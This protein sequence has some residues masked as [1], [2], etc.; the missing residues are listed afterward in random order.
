MHSID[1]HGAPDSCSYKHLA[2]CCFFVGGGGGGGGA[3]SHVVRPH[4]MTSQ[5]L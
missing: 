2:I 1:E 3:L 5:V 4:D